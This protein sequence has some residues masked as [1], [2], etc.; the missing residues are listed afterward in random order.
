[1]AP[2]RAALLDESTDFGVR[3]ARRLREDLAGWLVT[4]S[5]SGTPQPV[6]VWFV[7]D[8]A[9]TIVCYSQPA[10]AKLRNI[11]R[12]PQVAFHLDGN[13]KGENIIVCL[14]EAHVSDEPP[15]PENGAYMEKYAARIAEVGQTP[16]RFGELF[17]APYRIRV[18]RI[19]GM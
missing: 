4:V 19:R 7:W 2:D 12:H 9:D 15:I 17:T 16:E 8:G 10:Q 3:A 18:T 11:A 5:K 14:G 1:M 13:R 6:P